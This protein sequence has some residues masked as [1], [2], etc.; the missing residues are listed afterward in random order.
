MDQAPED[1]D[2]LRIAEF[3]IPGVAIDQLMIKVLVF[4]QKTCMLCASG[5]TGLCKEYFRIT[6]GNNR[7]NL[8][9][10]Y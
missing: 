10:N 4:C 5:I 3:A 2:L 9:Q 1:Q 7:I 8:G 6:L